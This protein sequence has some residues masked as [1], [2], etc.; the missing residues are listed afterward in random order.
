MS[1]RRSR[2]RAARTK[3]CRVPNPL[4]KKTAKTC[5]N[6]AVLRSIRYAGVDFSRMSSERM[7]YTVNVRGALERFV[8]QQRFQFNRAKLK[9]AVWA[10]AAYC[11]PAELGNVKLHKILYYADMLTFL[12]E[13]HPLT[14]VDYLKQKFGPTARHLTATIQELSSEGRMTVETVEHHGFYKKNYIARGSDARSVLTASEIALLHEVAD[15]VRGK[16]ASQISE[17]SHN[18]A[19]EAAE[20]GEVIPYQSVLMLVP[21]EVKDE[22]RQW[23]LETARKYASEAPSF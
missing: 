4:S 12:R 15:F 22:D 10:I 13:G 1:A 2:G 6:H 18:A 16:T 11:P 21:V 3:K 5:S 9:E 17:I 19:W 14:G 7:W 23:A 20:L 8:G